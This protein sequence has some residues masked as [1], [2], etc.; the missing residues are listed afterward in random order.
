M[1]KNVFGRRFKRDKNQRKALLKGLISSLVLSNRIQT[2]EA[3]AKAIKGEVDKVINN[4]K[5]GGLTARRLISTHLSQIALEKLMTEV[6]SR[7]NQRSS[8]YTRIIRVNKRVS[9]G[10][11]LVLMEFV[12]EAEVK[13]VEVKEV[14]AVK[15]AKKEKEEKE[16]KVDKK[17]TKKKT[18]KEVKK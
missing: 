16:V 5:K 12:D 8:G 15:P 4:A 18:K 3:K 17:E 7:F 2:T 11:S 10:A 1:R 14:K 6:S 9:D 13:P